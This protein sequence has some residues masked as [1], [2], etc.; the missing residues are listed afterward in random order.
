[1]ELIEKELPQLIVGLDSL[2]ESANY[3][4]IT[5]AK[6]NTNYYCPCCKGL[7][8]PRAYKKGIDY[9]VQPHFYHET[10]GCSD[11]TYI[12]YI[13][14]NWLFE[15]GCKFIINNITYEV[16]NIEIEKT[17]HTSFGDYR[18]DIIVTTT[19][20]KVFY[21]E[22]KTTNKKTELYAPKWDE[23]GN[24][25]VE[26]DTRY[27]IN[28][29]Y[30]N[31]I[32]VFNLIYS[33]G[34]CFIKTYSRNDYEDIIAKRKLEWKRQDKLN[35][36]IQWERLDWFWKYLQEYKVNED[37]RKYILE[38]FEKLDFYDMGICW[39]LVFNKSQ[40]LKNLK[41]DIR[42]IINNKSRNK[43]NEFISEKKEKYKNVLCFTENRCIEKDGIFSMWH[44]IGEYSLFNYTFYDS[45]KMS[46][47]KWIL[48]PNSIL[49]FI[50]SFN[51]KEIYITEH[52][53]N[54]DTIKTWMMSNAF[55]VNTLLLK[56]CGD[57]SFSYYTFDFDKG[58][59]TDSEKTIDQINEV[60]QDKIC[61]YYIN[62]IAT[63]K[64]DDVIEILDNY[65][66]RLSIC[67]MLKK[68]Y[69][70]F[71]YSV[72]YKGFNIVEIIFNDTLITIGDV[73]IDYCLYKYENLKN[74]INTLLDNEL[75]NIDFLLCNTDFVIDLS[76]Y[77][78]NTW[79]FKY[80]EEVDSIEVTLSYL[81][82]YLNDYNERINISKIVNIPH[83]IFNGITILEYKNVAI[84][85]LNKYVAPIMQQM[86]D[87]QI[88]KY[89]M[90]HLTSV[91]YKYSE[92]KKNN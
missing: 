70:N 16:E 87:D 7:I 13:C 92:V 12:H 63:V 50:E 35:Y 79:N 55:I 90:T 42:K 59:I 18:P 64:I 19:V 22:I 41:N 68:N 61:H 36:K 74:T 66:N 38:T 14:K 52:I 65:F 78:N 58:Y 43:F 29:K 37:A 73:N 1:M 86:I 5:D 91:A 69:Y 34:E 62:N 10:G 4:H 67:D 83:S 15:K 25:V 33:D 85:I 60:F 46:N 8:K 17:L 45:I 11:E 49:E 81:V 32:P 26:V 31:D 40:C 20:G 39:D 24:D 48:H 54:I 57:I 88:E 53:K 9:Q 44:L 82:P 21:F 27:F 76:R 23:L 47:K 80:Y 77:S 3:I 51:S 30:K 89:N 84:N 28:Q 2:D 75:K 72:K 56:E 71:S 6:E